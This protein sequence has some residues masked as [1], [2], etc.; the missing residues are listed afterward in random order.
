MAKNNKTI[1][2]KGIG[3]GSFS[4]TIESFFLYFTFIFV[5]MFAHPKITYEF[6]TSKYLFLIIFFTISMTLFLFRKFK[7][8]EQQLYFSWAHFG[9]FLFGIAAVVSTFTVLRENPLYFPFSFEIGI[10]TFLTFFMVLYFSNFLET[11]R[12]ITYFLL[13]VMISGTMVSIEALMN[14]YTGQSFFLGSYGSGGKMSIKA[15]IGNPNF[16]SDFLATLLPITIYFVLSYDFGWTPKKEKP[17]FEFFWPIIIIKIL[18]IINFAVFYFLVL[19]IGTRS[20]ILSLMISVVVFALAWIYYKRMRRKKEIVDNYK[21]IEGYSIKVANML[22]KINF[23]FMI[24][25]IFIALLLPI[26]LSNPNNPL[27]PGT[28]V[29]SRTSSIF[30]ERGFQTTGGKVR[31]L[32]WQASI[33]QFKDYPLIGNGIG[34]YM[35]KAITYMGEATQDNPE[36][37]DAWSNFKRT[38]NDYFQVLGEMGLF[39]FLAMAVTLVLLII[40]FFLIL[41]DQKNPDD[42]ILLILLATG[43]TVTLGHSF[44][45]FPLHLLP[46]QLWALAMAGLG[47]GR[48]FNKKKRLAFNLNLKGW[49]MPALIAIV[50]VV[51]IT[52]GWLKLNSVKA[53]ALFKEGNGYYSSFSQI[54]RQESELKN[55][56]TQVNQMFEQLENREGQYAILEPDIYMQQKIAEMGNIAN[57]FSEQELQVRLM[58]ELSKDIQ[59]EEQKL[60]NY[61]KQINDNLNYLTSERMNRYDKALSD[62]LSSLDSLGCY[63]KSMFYISLMM[64]RPERKQILYN[65]LNNSSDKM[66][67]ITNHFTQPDDSMRHIQQQYLDFPLEDDV[68]VLKQLLNEGYTSSVNE[69]LNLVNIS[70]WYD[71]QMYQAGIDYFETSFL[72]FNEKNSYRI[73]G[74]FNYNLSVMLKNLSSRYVELINQDPSLKETLMPLVTLHRAQSDKAINDMKKWYDQAIFILPGNW[75][76][77]PDWESI[78]SEYIDLLL[79][80]GTV[81]DVYP[82]VKE[83]AQK[84]VW[85]SEQMHDVQRTGVPD[86]IASVYSQIAQAFLENKLYQE[87]IYVLDDGLNMLST[88]YEWSIDDIVNNPYLTDSEKQRYQNFIS[89]VES[90]VEKRATFLD[91]VTS[92]YRYAKEQGE[93]EEKWLDDWKYNQFTG[94]TWEEANYEDIQKKVEEAKANRPIIIE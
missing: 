42:A 14:Y 40:M 38:H 75:Q 51:G 77:F 47:F 91:Q 61:I 58:N 90:L 74:K 35:H 33:Y 28:D 45:E 54:E 41:G 19:V 52:S 82:K 8:R 49:R 32:A 27:A 71:I 17:G 65:E 16:V 43:F 20:V 92:V 79:K 1:D 10:Y 68:Q 67:T 53:E 11:K 86:D 12:D 70:L 3:Q 31:L 60:N 39:G 6:S 57:Q 62:F 44:T 37:I 87:T 13:F 88:A 63:G 78:Y 23:I 36:Y 55:Q 34:T 72:C 89:T 76:A 5:A 73:M 2:L 84:R 69:L 81:T 25:I 94:E 26:L 83:I 59:E 21:K 9:W 80:S 66:E 93:F 48:Y 18:G 29:A 22:K 56:K 30:D 7:K 50:I 46:N 85:A 4:K 24:V 15:T 64:V